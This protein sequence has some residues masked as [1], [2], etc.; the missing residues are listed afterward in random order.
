MVFDAPLQNTADNP[1]LPMLQKLA[2][3][4][5]PKKK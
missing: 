3:L 2:S 4:I 1:A 5:Q